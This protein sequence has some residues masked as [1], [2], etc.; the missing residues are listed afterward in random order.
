MVEENPS[1]NVVRQTRKTV[2]TDPRDRQEMRCRDGVW[3][4]E[5]DRAVELR[6]GWGLGR[7]EVGRGKAK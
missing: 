3:D 5:G 7:G 2:S 1:R 4:T 6:R